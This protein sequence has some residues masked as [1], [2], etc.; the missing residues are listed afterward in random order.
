MLYG[1]INLY[2]LTALL[3]PLL[4]I[5]I[6]STPGPSYHG[7]V[8]TYLP[9]GHDCKNH[10]FGLWMTTFPV[11]VWNSNLLT[12]L[13]LRILPL[14]LSLHTSSHIQIYSSCFTWHRRIDILN[15]T[16]SVRLYAGACCVAGVIRCPLVGAC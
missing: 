3:R 6:P 10:E 11:H 13:K 1:N 12:V 16:I 9:I 14:T 7:S 5:V 8:N 2:N 4:G 15:S